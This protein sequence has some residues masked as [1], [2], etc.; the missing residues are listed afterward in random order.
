[1][2]FNNKLSYYLF[3][4]EAE[5]FLSEKRTKQVQDFFIALRNAPQY[6][7]SDENTLINYALAKAGLQNETLFLR[8]SEIETLEEILENR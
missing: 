6:L 8:E 4:A 2:A 5:G 3:M 7:G 1:M